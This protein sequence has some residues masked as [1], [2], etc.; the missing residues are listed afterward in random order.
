MIKFSPQGYR[1]LVPFLLP[2]AA[3]YLLWRAR[4][5]PSY[6]KHWGERFAW[7]S[8]PEAKEGRRRVWL[9]AVSVGETNATKPL[10]QAI[11]KEWPDAD[12]LLTHMT[13]TG[14]EAGAK[15]VALAPDRITQCFLPYD[16]VYAMRKFLRQTKP[17]LGLVMET[18]VWP[19]VLEEAKRAGI[20]VALVN[21]RLSQKSFDQAMSQPLVM[22]DAMSKFS[23]VCAQ[24]DSD[25]QRLK[26][27]GTVEPVV[28][29][30]LKFDIKAPDAAV[31]KGRAWRQAFG[32]PVVMLASSRDGEEAL[33]IETLEKSRRTD[34]RYLLVPR[35][36]QRFAEIEALLQKS[37]LRYQKR[38]TV[39]VP[40]DVAQDTELILGDSMGEM[41][42]Y[43]AMA[44]VVLMGGSFKPFGCQNVIEPAGLGVPVIVGPSTF[45]FSEVVRQ[46]K[47]AQAVWQVADM[48][49][50]VTLAHRWIDD[51]GVLS[52]LKNCALTFAKTHV[53]ATERTMKV[54]DKLWQK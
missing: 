49:E 54:L 31:Q 22:K 52:E 30:S 51:P 29:G 25:A 35:H 20:P 44:D 15:I 7:A 41:F 4:K 13:P 5:Q 46:G 17:D 47:A 28:T 6:L 12:I 2:A 19:T 9:H 1:L 48:A 43:C 38:S 34:I 45:N 24:A 39:E 40:Q 21:A 8:F 42:F 11:L 27:M 14:R 32:K 16:A 23:A 37:S 53:G 26:A 36:P 33:L 10:V 3:L 50:A 18:E